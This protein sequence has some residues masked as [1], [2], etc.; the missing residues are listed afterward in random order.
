VPASHLKPFYTKEA[1]VQRA[2]EQSEEDSSD[3]EHPFMDSAEEGPG[4]TDFI[5]DIE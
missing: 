2:A 1:L 5:P 3:S 4:E